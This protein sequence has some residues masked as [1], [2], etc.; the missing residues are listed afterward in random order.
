MGEKF[1]RT[2]RECASP[3]ELLPDILTAIR[4]VVEDD[5]LGEPESQVLACCETASVPL[6]RGGKKK[7]GDVQHTGMILTPDLFIWAVTWKG[8]VVVAWARPGEVRVGDY[9]DSAEYELMP[10]S[11]ID[12]F[13]FVRDGA[14]R[15]S[16]FI[17]LGEDEAARRFMKA[18]REAVTRA[19]GTLKG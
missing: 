13:G 7:E 1:E 3:E 5:G 11:G 8:R 14:T 17:G 19:G 12:L 18:L 6:K 4:A 16:A 2:T 10:D 15:V 9:R